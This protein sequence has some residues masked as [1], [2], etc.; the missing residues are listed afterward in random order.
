MTVSDQCKRED[1]L[2]PQ[3]IY[4]LKDIVPPK[5]A[6]PFYDR[7]QEGIPIAIDFGSSSCKIG[8]TNSE[9][10]N[11]VFP[12]LVARYRHRKSTQTWTII[13]SDCY[14][15]I[16][17]RTSMKSPYDGPLIN[18]WDYVESILD[19][20]LE[21]LGVTSNNGSVNNPVIMTEP[22]AC[23]AAQR[24]NMYE[25]LFEA[26][27][28][29]KVAFGIDS[30]FSYYANT[31][32]RN[33]DSLVIGTGNELTHIIPVIQGKGIMNQTKRIDWGGD[34][35][36]NLILKLLSLKYPYFPT[37]LSHQ[38]VNNIFYDH[39]YF[40]RDYK[41]ELENYL[42][43]DY[44]ETHDVVLQAPVDP[45]L[46][47]ER[48]KTQEE[49]AR[50]TEKKKEQGRR[51]QEQAQRKREE[52]LMLKEQEWEYYNTL[53]GEFER[54][55]PENIQIRLEE[56]NFDDMNDFKKYMTSLYKSLKRAH[57]QTVGE[58]EEEDDNPANAWPLVDIPDDQLTEEQIK[59]KRKQKLLKANHEARIRAKEEKKMEK[60]MEAEQAKEQEKWRERD[61]EG[62]CSVKR[63]E[64]EEIK[65]RLKERSKLLNSMKDRK[66]AAA[67]QRMKNIATLAN[68]ESGTTDSSRRRRRNPNA[69][70]DN[71]PNDT[72]GANDE[73]WSVYRE[74]NNAAIEEEQDDDYAAVL[75]LEAELLNFDPSFT[76]ED[77]MAAANTANWQNLS[78]HKFIHGPRPNITLKLQRE[79]TDPEEL[80]NR[81]EVI[82]KNHQMHFNIERIRVPE[83]L[84]QPSMAGVDQ[85]GISEVLQ[86]LLCRR[87]DNNFTIGGRSNSLIQDV[88]ITGGLANIPNFKERLQ[89][90][91]TEFLPIGAPLNVR[92]AANPVLDT[93]K[94][95]QMWSK[96]KESEKS[97]VSRAEYDEMGPEYIKEHNLGN[98][99]LQ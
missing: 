69:T 67:Q 81:P 73:D 39:C 65:V 98:V 97:Y 5:Q 54:T 71:D 50:Q 89:D 26:Y 55:S 8:M 96:S 44:L 16:I 48:K 18:N 31:G 4:Q 83:V 2:G 63:R 29:P 74:I 88:L 92:T 86:D 20:S 17:L 84:F 90:D 1:E 91:I 77:T 40:L 12:T 22:V 45:N 51:L 27:Q 19:Y 58:E 93:W 52:K 35:C 61:L 75:E 34:Q 62:W 10:P 28:A 15:N 82:T 53:Q 78:L 46:V 79:I 95:M 47:S 24:K 13:G 14:R 64:L 94:G 6:E 68:D 41:S 59:D 42:S 25:L 9:G 80:A 36:Q 21:H 57:S 23:P 60:E 37:K 7:Y 99:C 30:M 72:F 43:M 87:M 76:Q 49:L 38:N 66:S 11:N 70:I 85:A 56:E 32:A 3:K 33:T